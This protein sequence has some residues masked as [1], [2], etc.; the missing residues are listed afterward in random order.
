MKHGG[1]E[2]VEIVLRALPDDVPFA[3]R[4][5]A[6]KELQGWV[7]RHTA[8]AQ[9]TAKATGLPPKK[10]ACENQTSKMNRSPL[11]T[12]YVRVSDGKGETQWRYS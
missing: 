11:T 6:K 7:D 5:A 1:G 4:R 8:L 10:T 2:Q 9:L 3:V 12:D